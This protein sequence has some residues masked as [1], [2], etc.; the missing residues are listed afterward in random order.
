[1]NFF[2]I[3]HIEIACLLYRKLIFDFELKLN[4]YCLLFFAFSMLDS[5]FLD[6]IFI[7]FTN[8]RIKL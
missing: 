7:N 5:F 6:S 2:L 3:L 1:M 4:E 8:Q